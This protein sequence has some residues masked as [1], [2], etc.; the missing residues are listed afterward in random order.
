MAH[1]DDHIPGPGSIDPAE[2]DAAKNDGANGSDRD[3]ALGG[4][5]FESVAAPVL[6]LIRERPFVALAGAIL[7]GFL[8]S[9]ILSRR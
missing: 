5:D 9:K 8:V 7:A 4:G 3:G 1:L 2:L 6:A